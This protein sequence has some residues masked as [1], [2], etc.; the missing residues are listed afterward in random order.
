MDRVR[1]RRPTTRAKNDFTYS[2]TSSL[3]AAAEQLRKEQLMRS[4]RLWIAS[5]LRS[6]Q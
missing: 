5:S 1:F 2:Q 6:S 4:K 3:R